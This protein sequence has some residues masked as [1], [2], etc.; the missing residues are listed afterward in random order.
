MTQ[1]LAVLGI[2][3]IPQTDFSIES[4]EETGLTFVENALI[5]ARHASQ[6]TG[7]PCLADDS[8]LVIDVLNGEPGIYSSRYAGEQATDQNN[9]AKVLEK[10]HNVPEDKRSAHFHC[11]MVLMNGAHDP[12]PII[13]QGRWFGQILTGPKGDQGFGYDPIFFD[14]QINQVAAELALEEKNRVSHRGL[15]LKQ[16]IQELS[17]S[18]NDATTNIKS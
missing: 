18:Y 16:L 17:N 4:V 13:C 15:A 10:M 5:K 9:I 1:S 12:A 2:E 6:V 7:L 14:P 11:C 8:G 3:V